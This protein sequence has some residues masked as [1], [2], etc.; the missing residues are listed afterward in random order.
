MA[1]E[2]Q[3]YPMS[4]LYSIQKCT[5][6]WPEEKVTYEGIEIIVNQ[7]IQADDYSLRHITL[8]CEGEERSLRHYWYT[9]WPDQKTPDKAP[10]LLELVQ[11]VEEARQQAPEGSGPVIVHCSAGIGR[12][13]CF[14]ATTIG[15]KQLK[16][17]GVVDILRTTCQLRLNRG[18][19]IQTS[20]QYQFVHHVLSLYEKQLSL[21]VEE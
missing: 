20:E 14:I 19:M 12:T 7:V 1:L 2:Q 15:C 10:P 9:S 11:D 4:V 17:E 13:G 21:P 5:V 3:Q 16:N 18:G 8:K 6:Y